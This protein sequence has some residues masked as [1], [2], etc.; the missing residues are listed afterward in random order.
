M[1][2]LSFFFFVYR[3]SCAPPISETRG[4]GEGEAGIYK[5]DSRK[6]ARFSIENAVGEVGTGRPGKTGKEPEGPSAPYPLSHG[7]QTQSI[8]SIVFADD[9]KQFKP[10]YFARLCLACKD[11]KT[12]HWI[13]K[14]QKSCRLPGSRSAKL[15]KYYVIRAVQ[16]CRTPASYSN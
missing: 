6:W 7:F 14:N 13:K 3:G 5:V 15:R 2:S 12:I 11:F 4:R 10:L 1:C 9:C 16:N 8:A